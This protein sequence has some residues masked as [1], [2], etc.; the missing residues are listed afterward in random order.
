[1]RRSFETD[2]DPLY[3]CA[4]MLGGLQFRALRKELVESGKM[5]NREFHDSILKLNSMPVEMVRASL[6]GQSI[7]RDYTPRWRFY[8]AIQ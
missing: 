8:G 1:V 3:Q 6:T 2:Y 5:S 4:Y 7:A